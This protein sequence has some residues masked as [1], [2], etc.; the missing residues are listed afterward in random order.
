MDQPGTCEACPDKRATC[1][2]GTNV[3]PVAGYWRRTNM[4]SVF[5]KCFNEDAC[6]GM[7]APENDPK[8]SCNI[9]YKGVLCADCQPGFIKTVEY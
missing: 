3:G 6:L 7:F 2:G 5:L 1:Y 4:T 9:G 8:G